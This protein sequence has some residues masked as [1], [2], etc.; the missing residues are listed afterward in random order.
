VKAPIQSVIN[1]VNSLVGKVQSLLDKI[2]SLKSKGGDLLSHVGLR[3]SAGSALGGGALGAGILDGTKGALVDS[4]GILDKIGAKGKK[5]LEKL[6]AQL[7]ELKDAFASLRDSVVS[8]FAGDLFSVTATEAITDSEGNITTAAQSAGQNF[9]TSLTAKK[10]QLGQLSAAFK[11]LTGWG[12]KPQALAALFQ[13][14]NAALILDLANDKAMATQ[15]LGL[16]NDVNAQ[17][18]SLGAQVGNSVYGDSINAL[19]GQIASAGK[20]GGDNRTYA[21]TVNVPVNGDPVSTGRE[22]VKTIRQ[23][24]RSTGRQLLVTGG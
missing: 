22:I 7:K 9:I 5:H 15:G 3:T 23:L 17:S 1:L 4:M 19:N 6:K 14:G 24:E 21:I 12:W 20:G 2:A 11:T 13:S 10:G 18:A 8:A 16:Y